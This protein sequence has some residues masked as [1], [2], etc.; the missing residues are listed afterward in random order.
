MRG[1]EET[2]SVERAL[3]DAR[4]LSSIEQRM[5]LTDLT[6]YLPDDILTKVD[7][8]SMAV[9]LEARVPI[10]DHRVVEFAWRL[11]I[12]RKIRDGAGKWVLRRVLDEYVPSALVDRRKM[13]F[14]VPIGSWLRTSLR[15]WAEDLLTE[16]R[17]EAHGLFDPAPIRRLWQEHLSGRRQWHNLLWPVLVFQAWYERHSEAQPV[18]PAGSHA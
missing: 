17:L 10:L 13:G 8:A 11:P 3:R 14:G 12:D 7:R 5:M 4:W 15:P 6:Q 9:S 1:G 16:R 2:G 18:A